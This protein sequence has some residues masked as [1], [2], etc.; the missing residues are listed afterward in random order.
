MFSETS[1]E[2]SSGSVWSATSD[3]LV[4]D[5]LQEATAMATT[6]ARDSD[7][8]P[9]TTKVGEDTILVNDSWTTRFSRSIKNYMMHSPPPSAA[10]AKNK[11]PPELEALQ[12][13]YA[14]RCKDCTSCHYWM[15]CITNK[16]VRCPGCHSTARTNVAPCYHLQLCDRYSKDQADT[17]RTGLAYHIEFYTGQSKHPAYLEYKKN[18][19]DQITPI[20]S[21]PLPPITVQE[22]ATSG[23]DISKVRDST[24]PHTSTHNP[25]ITPSLS[26]TLP[27]NTDPVDL[28]TQYNESLLKQLQDQERQMLDQRDSYE[29]DKKRLEDEVERYRSRNYVPQTSYNNIIPPSSLVYSTA[30]PPPPLTTHNYMYPTSGETRTTYTLAAPPFTKPPAPPQSQHGTAQNAQHH[31]Q[32]SDIGEL[33]DVFKSMLNQTNNSANNSAAK[34]NFFKAPTMTLSKL[35][36]KGNKISGCDYHLW[37]KRLFQQI[38]TF[39]LQP[40]QTFNMLC[41]PTLKLI[42]HQW[43]KEITFCSTLD[44]IFTTLDNLNEAVELSLPELLS[45]LLDS[46]MAPDGTKFVI[47][48][49]AQLLKS[50]D[51]LQSLHPNHRLQ[52]H[53]ALKIL[54]NI[55]CPSVKGKMYELVQTWQKNQGT[56]PL[57]A[58]LYKYLQSLRKSSIDL[59]AALKMAGTEIQDSVHLSITADKHNTI[60]DPPPPPPPLLAKKK[61]VCCICN[62]EHKQKHRSHTCPS[63]VQ[64]K[65]NKIKLPHTVC[66]KCLRNTDNGQNHTT[67]NIFTSYN[68]KTDTKRPMNVICKVHKEVNYAICTKCPPNEYNATQ[69]QISIYKH[70]TPEFT[71]LKVTDS[72]SSNIYLQEIVTILTKTGEQR[73]ALVQ[74][75]TAGGLSLFSSKKPEYNH[76][77]SDYFSP[78]ILTTSLDTSTTRKYNINRILLQIE[79]QKE[80]TYI[81]LYTH[82]ALPCGG[83]SK[84]LN[85]T[86]PELAKFPTKRQIT[87]LPRICLGIKYAN[88]H[89]IKI[90][91]DNKI[92]SYDIKRKYPNLRFVKSQIT[93]KILVYGDK[94]N[95]ERANILAISASEAPTARIQKTIK[96]PSSATVVTIEDPHIATDL[97][98]Q[99]NELNN[100]DCFNTKVENMSEDTL[101]TPHSPPTLSTVFRVQCES[102]YHRAEQIYFNNLRAELEEFNSTFLKSIDLKGLAG[103]AACDPRI[104]FLNDKQ[105]NN[106]KLLADQV[107]FIPPKNN[108]NGHYEVSRKFKPSFKQFPTGYGTAEQSQIAINKRMSTRPNSALELDYRAAADYLNNNSE[109]I[110]QNQLKVYKMSHKITYLPSLLIYNVKSKSTPI[111][112]ALDP[113][114]KLLINDNSKTKLT[115]SYNDLV[116]EYSLKMT[117]I[118][119]LQL[120][121]V[122]CNN[123][124]TADVKDFFKSVHVNLPTSL[125]ALQLS[126]RTPSGLPTCRTEKSDGTG[127]HTLRYTRNTYGISD[128]PILSNRAISE[129]ISD[130]RLHSPKAKLYPDWLLEEIDELLSNQIYC[131]DLII[132]LKTSSIIKYAKWKNIPCPNTPKNLTN[133]FITEHATWCTK[134]EKEYTTLLGDALVTTLSFANFYLKPIESFDTEINN[135]FNNHP[136]KQEYLKNIKQPTFQRPPPHDVHKESGKIIPDKDSVQQT[137][138]KNYVK[139]LG[140]HFYND[141][142]IGLACNYLSLKTSKRKTPADFLYN[143]KELLSELNAKYSGKVTK[144]MVAQV[145]GSFWDPTGYFLAGPTVLIKLSMAKAYEQN[146]LLKWDDVIPETAKRLFLLGTE[147]FFYICNSRFPRKNILNHDNVKHYLV[148]MSDAGKYLHACSHYLVSA[149]TIDGKYTSKTQILMQRPFLNKTNINSIPYQELTA[150]SK[151]TKESV[152]ILKQLAQLDII[153]LPEDVLILTDS[154][155]AIVQAKNRPCLFS[156]RI[157]C[158]ISKIK[159][160]LFDA[161]LSTANIG[162]FQQ[163]IKSFIVDNL[164]KEYDNESFKT[165]DQREAN[166]R[167]HTWLLENPSTW[168]TFIDK[169]KYL[170]NLIDTAFFNN[171]EINNDYLDIAYKEFTDTNKIYTN[172][173]TQIISTHLQTTTTQEKKNNPFNTLLERK[174]SL[175]FNT[176]GA[177]TIIARVI[178][179]VKRLQLLINWKST[180]PELYNKVKSS[181]KKGYNTI[182]KHKQYCHKQYCYPN[183]IRYQ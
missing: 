29:R 157:G 160:N 11:N 78:T 126:L 31:T 63:L 5:A 90:S 137:S 86:I 124:I 39:N 169:G 171:I 100:H 92:I 175:G 61:Y 154:T 84:D 52:F 42:P 41:D 178:F 142:T 155:T 114:R 95:I 113:A 105:L 30:Q 74:Y 118:V 112:A 16:G 20:F 22:T 94:S 40:E 44:E 67:C 3:D 99:T 36:L 24:T 180:N 125:N 71:T 21:L 43:R 1:S 159:L 129:C 54:Y 173:N 102:R 69:L 123:L 93:K 56:I 59:V 144:R 98:G 146:N 37:R 17:Y 106:N 131:D 153:I 38:S 166:L 176:K 150:L 25:H 117:D 130:F 8:D 168:N 83:Y 9:N 182:R 81:D 163:K 183:T 33:V 89:P 172:L 111:R 62:N 82:E 116:Y 64:I 66:H 6:A 49:T 133:T 115:R 96:D 158:L 165:F 46:P 47:E 26:T 76:F 110:S 7:S 167:T 101:D 13:V 162:F 179:Y 104:G 88:L 108:I 132:N 32:R 15:T 152:N 103:C 181:L 141:N 170:P 58:S 10:G 120:S 28:Q 164:T 87:E 57:E 148:S 53:E 68:R 128:L 75:D 48:R 156:N 4:G 91:E 138:S 109:W 122:L 149:A 85:I 143:Q 70:N 139:Q 147:Y 12:A 121:Q 177:I 35:E 174:R 72:A 27:N 65:A 79:Q 45:N 80:K 119:K 51:E 135:T 97:T 140:R 161:K 107:K 60:I 50:L 18:I 23:A 34:N 134:L 145:L 77:E 14:L 136:A 127:F 151:V 55:N 19:E 2:T 73:Q